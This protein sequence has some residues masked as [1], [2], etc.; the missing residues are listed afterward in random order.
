MLWGI[1]V[2]TGVTEGGGLG[3]GHGGGSATEVGRVRQPPRLC[4]MVC[5]VNT[6]TRYYVP[7]RAIVYMSIHLCC[8]LGAGPAC[9]PGQ[10]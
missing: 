10:R 8:N 1:G 2:G 3:L 5:K 9:W 4:A 6:V 7:L